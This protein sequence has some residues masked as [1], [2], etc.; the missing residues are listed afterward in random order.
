MN[1]DLI[2]REAL[3][4]IVSRTR[5]GGHSTISVSKE[6]RDYM[7]RLIDNAPTAD[8]GY[9]EGHIDGVLQGEKLY[10]R[11]QGK[12]IFDSEY[13]KIGNPYGTY[14]CSLCGGHSSNKYPYCFWCGAEMKM[15]GVGE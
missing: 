4:E 13:T 8:K 2:S 11:P 6:M 3:K 12:W 1:N 9:T 7:N 15:K 10:A 14:K 5:F